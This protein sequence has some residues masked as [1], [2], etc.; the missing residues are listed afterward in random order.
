M[1]NVS[2]EKPLDLPSGA[3]K[4]Q[5]ENELKERL[6][7]IK[8]KAYD[9]NK[10]NTKEGRFDKDKFTKYSGNTMETN[11]TYYNLDS[12]T[13]SGEKYDK[14]A[15]TGAMQ[16]IDVGDLRGGKCEYAK[17]TN[18]VNGKSVIIK[19]NDRGPKT[20]IVIGKKPDINGKLEDVKQK[21]LDPTKALDLSVAAYA[22]ITHKDGAGKLHVKIEFLSKS[23][24][25]TQYNTQRRNTDQ[26]ALKKHVD[27]IAP[28]NKKKI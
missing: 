9:F 22:A 15:I 7:N 11:A 21:M 26:S 3:T 5:V 10:T 18:T 4:K 13:S 14:Y 1:Q 6:D 17:V 25:E 8:K 28:S 24:G 16:P 2:D 23:A 19:I 27:E 20:P 12:P